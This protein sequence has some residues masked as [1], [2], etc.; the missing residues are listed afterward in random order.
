MQRIIKLF[1]D[2]ING[3]NRITEDLFVDVNNM[4]S[5]NEY[6]VV[7]KEIYKHV[8]D[9]WDAEVTI[10][11]YQD[12]MSVLCVNRDNIL[13]TFTFNLPKY[14]SE[15]TTIIDG[16]HVSAV[17]CSIYKKILEYEHEHEHGRGIILSNNRAKVIH[18]DF[19][20]KHKHEHGDKNKSRS[21]NKNIS[22]SIK[23][24]RSE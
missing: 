19:K 2:I 24:E 6:E 23:K 8:H 22:M 18:V 3:I 13:Q 11:D 7:T 10:S 16:I 4:V 17:G 20:H 14:L 9:N 1:K 12:F 15:Q 5:D 21:K